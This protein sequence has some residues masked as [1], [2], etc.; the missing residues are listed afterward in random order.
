M[1]EAAEELPSWELDLP[2]QR[3]RFA[4]I[5]DNDVDALISNQENENT[6]K[7][8]RY[9]L[10][11]VKA[12]LLEVH[13]GSRDLHAI[14]PDELNLLLSQFIVAAR[15]KTGRNYEPSSLRG[16][17]S[18]ID[19]CLGRENYGKRLFVDPEFN[20]TRE[21]LK[22]RQK[23]LKQQGHGN[24]PRATTALTDEEIRVR[25]HLL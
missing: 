25:V 2:Q 5:T 7:K 17:L 3:R 1:A 18:S 12:Y 4:N 13:N 22:A 20:K 14:P 6:K 15:T 21:A 16:I 19:R 23:E 24:K 11:I 9:D 10:K 8:T